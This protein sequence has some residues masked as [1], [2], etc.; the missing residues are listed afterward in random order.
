MS[1]KIPS[2]LKYTATHE[3]VREETDG[4]IT[5]GITDH[6]QSLLGDIVY[7]EL[8]EKRQKLSQGEGCAVVESVKA[9]ADVYAPLAGEIIMSNQALASQPELVNIDPY[10]DGWL[11]QIKL[12]D[13]SALDTLFNAEDYAKSIFS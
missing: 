4:I 7:I 10:G 9:A 1:K 5:I 8:P 12:N 2:D 3:W 11:C 13:V 6:A